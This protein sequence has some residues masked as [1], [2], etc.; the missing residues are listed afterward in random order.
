M[1]AEYGQLMEFDEPTFGP[2]S[3]NPSAVLR[4]WIRYD[5]TARVISTDVKKVWTM[6]GLGLLGFYL[7]LFRLVAS[8]SRRLR[9]QSSSNR[10]LATHD[11]LTDLPNRSLLRDRCEQAL[12]ASART[13]RHI[14]MMLL[15]LDRF[16]EVNDTLGHHY[17]DELLKQIAARLR[18]VLRPSDTVGRLGGDEFVIL[19]TDLRDPRDAWPAAERILESFSQAFQLDDVTLNVDTSIGLAVAPQHGDD[20]DGLLQHADIAMYTAKESHAGFAMYS[21]EL[22]THTTSRLQLLG[23]LRR[24]MVETDQIVL[25]FQ[26]KVNLQSGQT[27][28]VEALVRWQHPVRGLLGPGEFISTAEGTGIIR[29]LTWLVLRKALEQVA[30]WGPASRLT[31]AVNVSTRCLLDRSFADTVARL[32]AETGISPDRL[33]LE[34]TESAIMTEPEH[35]IEVL[36]KL[37][38]MGIT[39]SIDDFGTGYS[40]MSYLKRLPVQQLKIDRTFVTDMTRDASADAIVRSSLQL[41]RNLG[42]EVVAEGVETAEVAHRLQETGCQ[43]AQGYFYARPMAAEDLESWLRSHEGA[44]SV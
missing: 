8:A 12:A 19:L 18:A 5:H 13:G 6:L 43:S 2:G 9:R 35:A 24:A 10:H 27:I 3:G 16:K 17:G 37:A 34:I 40:S 25:H 4:V 15:D 7:C 33:E 32:L 26:P 42:L 44:V 22:N 14:G 41:A 23:D 36:T 1:I 38:A 31:M 20:F 28:G 29:P 30:S 11:S 21:Y 39:L